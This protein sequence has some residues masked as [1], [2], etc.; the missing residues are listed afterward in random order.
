MSDDPKA[1]R[2]TIAIPNLIR[3][4]MIVPNTRVPLPT[5]KSTFTVLEQNWIFAQQW[6]KFDTTARN[7][8]EL[9]VGG[10]AADYLAAINAASQTARGREVILAVGHGGAGDFRGLSQTVFDSIPNADHGLETHPFAVSRTVL[11]LP[12]VAVKANGQWTPR[13]IKDPKTGVTT[14]IEQ[15]SIDKLSPRFDLIA[16]SGEIMRAAGVARFV[17]LACNIGKDSPPPGKKG[18]LDLLASILGVEVVAY[19]GLVAIGEVVFTNPGV[20]ANTKEQIWIATD[21]TDVNRG[22]PSQDDPDHA[23]FHDVPLTARVT[24]AAPSPS[25]SPT[26]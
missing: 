21:E 13:A 4:A 5:A 14:R 7:V 23:S 26:P 9:R 11:D 16:A 10:A 19:R 3:D 18:F 6:K 17:V 25:P 24:A 20:P 12:D 1:D 2:K 15:G 22:R 8:V